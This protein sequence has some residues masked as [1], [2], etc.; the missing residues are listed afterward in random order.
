MSYKGIKEFIA[1]FKEP[2]DIKK[3]AKQRIKDSGER[4]TKQAIEEEMIILQKEYKEATERGEKL[5]KEI[6]NKKTKI[7]DCIVEGWEKFDKGSSPDLSTNTLQNNKTYIEKRIISDKYELVGYADE[8]EVKK[9]FINIEDTKTW[10]KIYR[11]S[12]IRLKNG[13]V[14]PPT[15]YYPPVDNTPACNYYDAA[16]QISM[17]MYIL[18]IHNKKLKPGKLV[19]RHIK[20][21]DNDKI[22]EEELIEVPYLLE[23]VKKLLKYRIKNG[24]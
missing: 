1:E 12:V 22:L 21:N 7:K 17:Y 24:S 8:V 19:I 13:F 6:Q 16:L 18:W 10:K 15:Y 3:K 14:L 20:T 23:E 9:N 2:F 4:A 11:S 5:H